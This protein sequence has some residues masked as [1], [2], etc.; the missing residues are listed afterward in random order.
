MIIDKPAALKLI[1]VHGWLPT[2][3]TAFDVM[4]G[5]PIP[6]TSFYD[7]FGDRDSYVRAD[8][9]YWLGY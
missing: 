5:F 8:I 1:R 7:N 9:M 2:D 3:P 4:T 6:H